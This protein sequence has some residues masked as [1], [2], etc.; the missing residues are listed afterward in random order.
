MAGAGGG[1][2]GQSTRLWPS[3]SSL[4][5]NKSAHAEPPEQA[6]QELLPLPQAPGRVAAA[7]RAFA[8]TGSALSP[9]ATAGWRADVLLESG[10]GSGEA[11]GAGPGQEKMLLPLEAQEAQPIRGLSQRG[12]RRWGKDVVSDPNIPLSVRISDWDS[13]PVWLWR[14]HRDPDRNPIWGGTE[15]GAASLLKADLE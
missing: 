6:C 9:A 3:L 5:V 10:R 15:V 14:N 11:Q 12:E 13:G 7:L 8:P 4:S 2:K 1:Q